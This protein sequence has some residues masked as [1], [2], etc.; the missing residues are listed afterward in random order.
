MAD[1]FTIIDDKNYLV[2]LQE[3]LTEPEYCAITELVDD[4][5]ELLSTNWLEVNEDL[6]SEHIELFLTDGSELLILLVDSEGNQDMIDVIDKGDVISS[7]RK[8]KI[9]M[10]K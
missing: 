7:I 9:K 10:I 6:E 3:D 2:K 1:L 4:N 5:Y 8:A